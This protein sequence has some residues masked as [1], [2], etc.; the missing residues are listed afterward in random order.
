MIVKARYRSCVVDQQSRVEE[1]RRREEELPTIERTVFYNLV[2]AF[3]YRYFQRWT[4]S[5][6]LVSAG[7]ENTF[8]DGIAFNVRDNPAS[9]KPGGSW[10]GIPLLQTWS[11]LASLPLDHQLRIRIR[12]RVASDIGATTM[13]GSVPGPSACG[14]RQDP[15]LTSQRPLQYNSG[16]D[17]PEF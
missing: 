16:F 10:S 8:V 4:A 13:P 5:R 14:I 6:S 7:R 2:M 1:R 3:T 15:N 11:M 12:L 9:A 17:F